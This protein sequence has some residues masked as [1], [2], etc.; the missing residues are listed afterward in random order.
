[1]GR[2]RLLRCG[3]LLDSPGGREPGMV[4]PVGVNLSWGCS[5]FFLDFFEV[6]SVLCTKLDHFVRMVGVF[7]FCICVFSIRVITKK[8]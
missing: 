8:G 4:S 3:F 5:S 7:V 2:L 1:M 6:Q